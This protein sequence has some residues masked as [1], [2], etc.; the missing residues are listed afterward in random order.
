MTGIG[1]LRRSKAGDLSSRDGLETTFA[2][3]GFGRPKDLLRHV[4]SNKKL[5]QNELAL[6]AAQATANPQTPSQQRQPALRD[7]DVPGL[8]QA[9]CTWYCQHVYLHVP[10]AVEEFECRSNGK[11]LS[12]YVARSDAAIQAEQHEEH[13]RFSASFGV[14]PASAR[15]ERGPAWAMC[16]VLAN[17]IWRE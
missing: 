4:A 6:K 2:A 1:L 17:L 13:A 7:I 12:V 5:V 14:K 15:S 16:A 10:V 11:T 8:P 3:C 9:L